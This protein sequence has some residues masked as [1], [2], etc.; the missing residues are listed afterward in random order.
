MRA[1]GVTKHGGPEALEVVDLPEAHA[2]PGQVRIRNYAATVNPTDTFI[3]NGMRAREG[4]TGPS[5]PGMDAAGIIDEVGAGVTDLAVGDRVM[6]IVAPNGSHGAY[7]SSLVLPARSVVRAPQ[8]S[9]HAE[10]STLPMN[11]LTARLTLDLLN[12]QPGQTLAVTG[13]AGCYGGY[14][15]QLAKI[16][17]LRVIADASEA[18]R[19][20]VTKLGA[21]VVLPRGETF[22]KAVR[23]ELAEGVDALADGSVQGPEVFE[24]IRDGGGFASVRGWQGETPRGITVHQVWVRE[25]LQEQEKLDLLRQHVEDGLLTLRVAQTFPADE[26]AEAHRRLEAGGVRGR[27]VLEF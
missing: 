2:G 12:L 23:A 17:G 22:A 10:A 25:Y 27:L 21:D 3:R 6:A 11:A 7:S 4:S 5:I 20:L 18:D 13:A 24:A 19:E 16:D 14:V 15:V 8:G 26:A 9:S 1:V